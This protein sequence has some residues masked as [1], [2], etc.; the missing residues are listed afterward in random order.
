[1]M[2]FSLYYF[3]GW[4]VHENFAEIRPASPDRHKSEFSDDWSEGSA[5]CGA[6]ER[7]TDEILE[8]GLIPSEFEIN[9]KKEAAIAL[10]R[11]T[12]GT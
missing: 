9:R 3:W 2:G 7:L 6:D 8:E 10:L 11:D 5:L 4:K 12:Y 1:M